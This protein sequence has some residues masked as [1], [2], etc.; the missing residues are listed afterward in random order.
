MEKVREGHVPIPWW[1]WVATGVIMT[2]YSKTVEIKNPNSTGILLFFYLGIV[3][4][5]FGLGKFVMEKK[6]GEVV[7]E[8]KKEEKQY[9]Q[10]L[11]QQERQW[12]QQQQPQATQHNIIK[13][14]SCGAQH[15]ATSNFCH[16]CGAKLR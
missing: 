7:Q 5:I 10:Q 3:I 11:R 9:G 16:R 1:A 13:C 12:Q 15:Y 6:R 8:A 14:P 4:S 2:V